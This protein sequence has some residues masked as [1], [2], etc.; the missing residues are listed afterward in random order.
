MSIPVGLLMDGER[1]GEVL[2]VL[3]PSKLLADHMAKQARVTGKAFF[4]GGILPSKI[5]VMNQD[6]VWE[7]IQ[8]EAMM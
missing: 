2:V 8:I 6:G 5:E 7:D 3:A 4:D 1:D